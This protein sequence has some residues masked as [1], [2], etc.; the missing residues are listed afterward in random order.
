MLE[1]Y[2][3]EW[4][5]QM[6]AQMRRLVPPKTPLTIFSE[7]FKDVPIQL[8][9]HKINNNVVIGYTALLDVR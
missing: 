8:Q 6:N 9:A 3:K 7:L 2:K 1:H 5:M 4:K